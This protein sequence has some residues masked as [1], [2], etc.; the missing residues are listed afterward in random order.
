MLILSHANVEALLP[1]ADCI[2]AIDDAMRGLSRGDYFNPLRMKA[3]P[4]GAPNRMVFM[5]ALRRTGDNKL[6][7]LKQ[8]VVT[9]SNSQ[10]GLDSHQGAVLLH[11]G[12]TGELLAAVHAGA[13]TSIRT[14]AASAVATRALARKDARVVTILG[15]GVQG[16]AHLDAMRSILPNA[17]FRIWSR[18]RANA[19]AIAGP[20][21]AEVVDTVAAACDGAD[22]ICAVTAAPEPI[23]NAATIP[24][25]CHVNAAGSSIATTR[26]LD[27]AAMAKGTLFV[28]RRE[29]TVNE[30]GDYLLA[31]REG[32]ITSDHVRAEIGEV[33]LGRHPGRT[34]VEEVTIYKSLGVAVQDL[35]AA[36]LAVRRARERGIGVEAPF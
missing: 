11:D 32:A 24:R 30:S 29:S 5:P 7:G 17:S 20:I 1:M 31:L 3:V 26:E 22:V 8:I 16:R 28:D 10:R 6:W 21:G 14:A 12:D 19:E 34:S 25:G 9:P 18:H 27:G 13:I 35:A 33:L 36:E 2:E 4:E 15:T 23:L